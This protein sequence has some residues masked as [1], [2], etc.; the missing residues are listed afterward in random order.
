M[1]TA[2][3]FQKYDECGY[4]AKTLLAR[5]LDEHLS[6]RIVGNLKYFVW[7]AGEANERRSSHSSNPIRIFQ[8][9]D[10]AVKSG[11]LGAQKIQETLARMVAILSLNLPI[12]DPM[13]ENLTRELE[14]ALI[15]AFRPQLWRIDLARWNSGNYTMVRPYEFVSNG[16]TLPPG[17]FQEAVP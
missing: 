14:K 1:T 3:L 8:E 4:T 16:Y 7:F 12:D 2:R 15:G 11:E 10:T 5:W 13:F 6:V 17:M 9:L